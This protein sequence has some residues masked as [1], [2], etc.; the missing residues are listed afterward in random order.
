MKTRDSG[1]IL[2]NLRGYLTKL[3]REGVSTDL[4]RTIANEWS[5]LDP[6]TSGHTWMG[7]HG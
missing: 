1:L 7:K 2:E 4:D 5:R 6:S 3:P